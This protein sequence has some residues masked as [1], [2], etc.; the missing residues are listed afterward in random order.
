M[1]QKPQS[2]ETMG[3]HTQAQCSLRTSNSYGVIEVLRAALPRAA[4][5]CGDLARGNSHSTP[6]VLPS[7]FIFRS[8]CSI[9]RVPFSLFHPSVFSFQFYLATAWLRSPFSVFRSSLHPSP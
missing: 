8:P 9:L 3:N 6:S 5:A 2:G 7:V 4:F 1:T